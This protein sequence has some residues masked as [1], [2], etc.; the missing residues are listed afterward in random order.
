MSIKT[1]VR[2]AVRSEVDKGIEVAVAEVLSSD[3]VKEKLASALIALID[4]EINEYINESDKP[5]VVE[6]PVEAMSTVE[7]LEAL[8]VEEQQVV[9][10]EMA[11]TGQSFIDT[12]KI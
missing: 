12:L 5:E 7:V 11:A 3:V 6:Q 2:N 9:L 4:S 10:E 8:D 1:T